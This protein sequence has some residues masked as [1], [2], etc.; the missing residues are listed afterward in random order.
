MLF[1]SKDYREISRYLASPS[2]K[3]TA[4]S[5]TAS[6]FP[7]ASVSPK[8]SN[9]QCVTPRWFTVVMQRCIT[10]VNPQ[11]NHRFVTWPCHTTVTQRSQNYPSAPVAVVANS[12]GAAIK[13][14]PHQA[15][16]NVSKCHASDHARSSSTHNP[17]KR[18][19]LR[20]PTGIALGSTYNL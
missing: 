16:A 12:P 19:T 5:A 6:L 15:A 9:P 20:Q 3:P 17:P 18:G 10:T 8:P 7:L 1:R 2:K 13:S 14:V 11:R 4:Q